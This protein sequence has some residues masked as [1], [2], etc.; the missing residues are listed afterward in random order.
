MT[1]GRPRN[2]VTVKWSEL[3]QQ[4]GYNNDKEM[5]VDI[6][7]TSKNLVEAAKK[8]GVSSTTLAERLNFYKHPMRKRG[9]SHP[10][11]V[12]SYKRKDKIPIEE[13]ELAMIEKK[14]NCCCEIKMIAKHLRTCKSCKEINKKYD[15]FTPEAL[16]I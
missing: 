8:I 1:I 13:D 5:C 10:K 15:N 3:A 2:A 11:H 7:N 14:C 6:Y 4:H 16:L 12:G 9:G